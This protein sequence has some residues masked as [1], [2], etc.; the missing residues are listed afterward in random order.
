MCRCRLSACGSS[1]T[2]WDAAFKRTL[3]DPSAR[4]RRV[5]HRGHDYGRACSRSLLQRDAHPSTP[6]VEHDMTKRSCA[7]RPRSIQTEQP[8]RRGIVR[9]K[10]TAGIMPGCKSPAKLVVTPIVSALRRRRRRRRRR[11]E[12]RALRRGHVSHARRVALPVLPIQDRLLRLVMDRLHSHIDTSSA[13]FRANRER[14]QALVDGASRAPR[15]GRARAAARS[16]WP[17]IANKASCRCA[18]A[19]RR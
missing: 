12:V 4:A 13:D 17:A 11:H 3:N 18:S 2:R 9:P 10:R 15:A 1:R 7:C 8:S 6:A 16:T 14:M 5:G 19:S